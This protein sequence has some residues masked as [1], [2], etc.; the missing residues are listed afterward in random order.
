MKTKFADQ[1]RVRQSVVA[2]LS[3]GLITLLAV[4]C[5]G[6]IEPA[7][8][9]T[10]TVEIPDRPPAQTLPVATVT[11]VGRADL[12][13]AAGAAAD[14]VAGG[15]PL[16]KANLELVDRSFELKL[17]FGCGGTAPADWG[18]WSIDPK[19]RVLRITVRPQVWGDDPTIKTLAAGATYDAAEGFWISR[20]WTRS[21][22]CPPSVPPGAAPVSATGDQTPDAV[23]D[24]PP[25]ETFA[26][27]Q[28]FSPDAPR[29][30]R[31]GSRPYSYTGKVPETG[32]FGTKGFRLKLAGR[33]R[34]FGDG[35]P[36]HCV[37][38]NPSRPP[39]C[40]AKVEFMQVALEDVATG[41]SLVDWGN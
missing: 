10:S 6:G 31:R 33:I 18:K 15:N 13:T 27:V 30:L 21:E 2:G 24:A 12:L 35:Q 37:N 29:T 36:I 9:Q 38:I 32:I 1:W 16:P 8:N 7:E 19:T 4:G 17:P 28:Y 14:D 23:P 25:I 11:P 40:A 26:I 5:H 3:L 41:E 39:V 22:T 34:A 20:P